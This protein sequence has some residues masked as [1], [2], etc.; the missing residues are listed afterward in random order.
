MISNT[1]MK[2]A[3]VRAPIAAAAGNRPAAFEFGL[4]HHVPGR[5]RLRSA[6]LKGNA[7]ASEQAR[8]Q[9]AQIRGVTATR[10][11]PTTGSVLLEY[12]PSV[13]SEGRVIDLLAAQ[14]YVLRAT[15]VEPEAGSGWA[16]RMASAVR[17]WV[18]NALAERLALAVITALA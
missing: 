13:L 1:D 17:D 5:L 9:L 6:A 7:S 18:I 10:A 8:H 4:A 2:G 3:A 16:D 14:G 15:E 11:N 12:D